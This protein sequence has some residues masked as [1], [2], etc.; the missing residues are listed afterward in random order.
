MTGSG[1]YGRL[2]RA[3]LRR[4]PRRRQAWRVNHLI[5]ACASTGPAQQLQAPPRGAQAPVGADVAKP[6]FA[7]E[8]A[9]AP[10]RVIGG[11]RQPVQQPDGEEARA[12]EGALRSAPVGD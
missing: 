2:L 7:E 5:C 1:L 12:T 9:D 6:G 3:R 8:V 4:P 11:V 10:G